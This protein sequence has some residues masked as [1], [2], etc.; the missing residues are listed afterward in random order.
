MFYGVYYLR[1]LSE[2]PSCYSIGTSI[3]C[4]YRCIVEQVP[5]DSDDAPVSRPS[6]QHAAETV[7]GDSSIESA[8]SGKLLVSVADAGE[9][10]VVVSFA[11][12]NMGKEIQRELISDL[13]ASEDTKVDTSSA[14]SATADLIG[15]LPNS[16]SDK[17]KLSLS[18][19]TYSSLQLDSTFLTSTKTNTDDNT[20]KV[21]SSM[22]SS[23][24]PFNDKWIESG[25]DLHLG[26][27]LHSSSDGTY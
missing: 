18:Q 17:L 25:L 23:A 3:R 14:S 11:E 5:K 19:D 8:F 22:N 6:N 27:S 9:T 12:E 10:A 1:I 7:N 2:I 4:S 21:V 13:L 16:E 15:E 24:T 26:L 20:V